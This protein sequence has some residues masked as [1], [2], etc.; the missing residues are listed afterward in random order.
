[1]I[2][3][4]GKGGQTS[5]ISILKIPFANCEAHE[6][7]LCQRSRWVVG[8]S[9]ET[10]KWRHNKLLSLPPPFIGF[11]EMMSRNYRIPLHFKKIIVTES[12]NWQSG[13][14]PRKR[15]LKPNGEFRKARRFLSAPFFVVLWVVTYDRHR[16]HRYRNNPNGFPG[17]SIFISSKFTHLPHSLQRIFNSLRSSI[18][19]KSP[20]RILSCAVLLQQGQTLPSLPNQN[21]YHPCHP[22]IRK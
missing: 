10:R 18:K 8:I 3:A 22:R 9:L 12:H 6:T 16:W 17:F 4:T 13:S 19:P 15:E 20:E 7:A 21:G 2:P 5:A 11:Q 14:A 1:M